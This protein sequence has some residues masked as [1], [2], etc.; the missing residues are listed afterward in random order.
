[1][2]PLDAQKEIVRI[3]EK[4]GSAGTRPERIF[5]DWVKTCRLTLE[6]RVGHFMAALEGRAYEDTDEA[7]AHWA[8]LIDT[9]G[10]GDRNKARP[11][12]ER[13]AQ[14]FHAL[15]SVDE[16]TDVVGPIYMEWGGGGRIAGQFFTPNSIAQLMAQVVSPQEAETL[17]HEELEKAIAKSVAA[18]TLSIAGHMLPEE[19][20]H[21]WL[22]ARVIPH[23]YAHY[24]PVK[25]SD[26][27]CGSGVMFLAH[28]STMPAWMVQMGMVQ[29]FGQ[30][31]SGVCVEMAKTN[32][33]LHGLNGAIAPILIY[34]AEQRLTAAGAPLP[35]VDVPEE[36]EPA[37]PPEPERPAI[38]VADPVL[39]VTQR[40][41]FELLGGD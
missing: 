41:L 15:Q 18:T 5:E 20:R 16:I 32:C 10:N 9:Y 1:M 22:L 30:D 24:E 36:P 14:A 40:S 7:K 12:L 11:H 39:P 31:I 3:L 37:P 6:S 21:D 29:Y 28:A 8:R 4:V 19:Q 27:A 33:Q 23:A 13:F 2:T 17:V 26:L 38:V 35:A 34:E 25:V